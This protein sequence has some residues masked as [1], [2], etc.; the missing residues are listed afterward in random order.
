MASSLGEWPDDTSLVPVRRGLGPRDPGLVL[1]HGRWAIHGEDYITALR[2]T[3]RKSP[4]DLLFSC[5]MTVTCCGLKGEA[6]EPM[7]PVVKSIGLKRYGDVQKDGKP[8]GPVQLPLSGG[9]VWNSIHHSMAPGWSG[10]WLPVQITG[11]GTSPRPSP[12]FQCWNINS[13]MS[14]C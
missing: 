3:E 10:P 5:K 14:I 11:R 7:R 1:G 6:L 12:H 8:R 4:L 13:K 9:E 2:A